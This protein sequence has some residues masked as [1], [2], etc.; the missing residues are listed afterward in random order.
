MV[1]NGHTVEFGY[2]R[3]EFEKAVVDS[4]RDQ[5]IWGSIFI[6]LIH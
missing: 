5:V 1:W 6:L 2:T 4:R 3:E